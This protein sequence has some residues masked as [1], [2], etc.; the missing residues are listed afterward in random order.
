MWVHRFIALALAAV[1]P[2]ACGG[3]S[4]QRT[5]GEAGA[6]SECDDGRVE[7]DGTCRNLQTDEFNCGSC[8][9]VCRSGQICIRGRCDLGAECAPGTALCG[10][11]CVDVTNSPIHCGACG[12]TCADGFF[13]SNG[14]CM[15]RCLTGQCGGICVDLGYDPN[16]CG[17][18]GFACSSGQVCSQGRCLDAC[19]G[20][21]CNGECVDLST[22]QRHCGG[23]NSQCPVPESFCSGGICQSICPPEYVYCS[24]D[25]VDW[26]SDPNNCGSCGRSCPDGLHCSNG[27]CVLDECPTGTYCNGVCT[28]I[29]NDPRNC[30]GCGFACMSGRCVGATC[31]AGTCGDGIVQPGEE[32]DPPPGELTVVPLNP[33]TCRYDFSRIEQ[34][35]CHRSCGNWGG[36]ED[37][38]DFDAHVFCKLKMD[39]PESMAESYTIT[40]ARAQPGVCCPPPTYPPGALG[41]T[42]LGVLASRGV[43]LNVS[44][45]PSDVLSTHQDGRVIIGLVC[46]DP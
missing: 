39:N 37:C 17:S 28:D 32:A 33:A 11:E 40:T 5:G 7:C 1:L 46:S 43:S 2:L 23:C 27:A 22:D 3:K 6:G 26:R 8:G 19:M 30:G 9:A 18:C 42:S 29:S 13:C 4:V 38:D 15:P 36:G 14:A 20:A 16:N 12:V 31:A 35:Y 24:G 41:C 45:H 34:W 25:C 21:I 10:G 44:V